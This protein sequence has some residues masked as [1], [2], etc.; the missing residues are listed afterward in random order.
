MLSRELRRK[1][2]DT[3]ELGFP[4]IIP[5]ECH[6]H[7]VPST[8]STII[9]AR[10]AGKSCRSFQVAND[11]IESGKL[12][13]H[14]HVCH[15]DFD[16]PILSTME[17]STL[18]E[19]QKTFLS[20]N[21]EFDLKTPIMFILD[22]IHK[23]DGWEEYVIDLS[24]NPN[25]TVVVTGS[26]S[27]LLKDEISTELRG[28]AV[29]SVVYPLSFSEYLSF[30]R[31][32]GPRNSTHG[33]A[34][35]RRYFDLYLKW[36]GYPALV[37]LES[38]NKEAV[39]REYFDTMILKDIIQRNNVS[40]PRQCIQLYNF[41]LSNIARP[42]TLK[43]AYTYLK[44]S[45]YK[46]SRDSISDYISWAEDAWLLSVV[47]LFSDSHKEQERNYKKLYAIDWGLAVR[48]STVWDG[49]FSRA[50]ENLV[51]LHLRRIYSRVGYYLT[52]TGRQEVDFIATD[53]T[54]NPVL[55]VQVST[56]LSNR[57]TLTRELEPLFKVAKFFDLKECLIISKNEEK[58]FSQDGYT[59]QIMPAWKWLLAAQ[60]DSIR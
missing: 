45:G 15:V 14:R 24:R 52:R 11:F 54:G 59:V 43:S 1:F 33:I 21:P 26:S 44:E 16:N 3:I 18:Q 23:I 58:S 9:G 10:R 29:T 50:L 19:I 12:S 42:H 6:V 51:Y 34:S 2:E 32:E 39:L 56:D 49:S 35:I 5:R 57:D 22:E 47:P 20:I 8:V 55:A 27:R 38:H 13:N 7:T 53:K 60:M 41:L 48:N 4:P 36:G 30:E 37:G 28:K 17:S 31:F 46:T 40:K 25:W